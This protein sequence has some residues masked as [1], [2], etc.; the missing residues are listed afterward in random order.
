MNPQLSKRRKWMGILARADRMELETVWQGLKIKP[1]YIFLR[2]PEVG[3]VMVQG[4]TAG[5][6]VFFNAGEITVTRCSV[7]V[8]DRF[9][10]TSCVMGRNKRHAE[11][12]AVFDALLHNP[13]YTDLLNLILIEPAYR[14]YCRKAAVT[15]KKAASTKVDFFTMV[16]GE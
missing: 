15:R 3:T 7:R 12:A 4:R 5:D 13:V 8:D 16:R 6:G 1:D 2:K 10:G 11:L 9:S 14:N